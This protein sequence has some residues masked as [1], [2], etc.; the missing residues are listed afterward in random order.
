M[1]L[2]LFFKKYYAIG[3]FVGSPRTSY[4]KIIITYLLIN[5]H[6]NTKLQT[7]YH[8]ISYSGFCLLICTNYV[9][10]QILILQLR[11]HFHFS[12]LHLSQFHACDFF[13]LCLCS[14]TQ[15]RLLLC[16]LTQKA[17]GSQWLC[18]SRAQRHCSFSPM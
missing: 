2:L 9:S 17:K 8:K 14:N 4:I 7:Q 16:C 1:V 18:E 3:C 5:A 6:L 13:I 12:S 11:L 10:S 15:K